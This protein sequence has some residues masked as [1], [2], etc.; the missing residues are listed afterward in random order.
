LV[1]VVNREL[2]ELI[3]EYQRI[4]AIQILSDRR[5]DDF[6][7]FLIKENYIAIFPF[8]NI[9]NNL[10]KFAGL[11]FLDSG[12]LLG[13]NKLKFDTLH[14]IW[15]RFNSLTENQKIK[16]GVNIST[17][18]LPYVSF[19][20]SNDNYSTKLQSIT[21]FLNY[22]RTNS[23]SFFLN[24]L[25]EIEIL[26]KHKGSLI[27]EKNEIRNFGAKSIL[28]YESLRNDFSKDNQLNLSELIENDEINY[29]LFENN[30]LKDISLE[31]INKPISFSKLRKKI[32]DLSGK[33]VDLWKIDLNTNFINSRIDAERFVFLRF[34]LDTS[35]LSYSLYLVFFQLNIGKLTKERRRQMFA[36][37]YPRKHF[38]QK[39]LIIELN[40]P[41][42]AKSIDTLGDYRL[43]INRNIL[44]FY[45][46]ALKLPGHVF[47][48]IT[49]INFIE[50]F[51]SL[52]SLEYVETIK[53]F[54]IVTKKQKDTF[55][56]QKLILNFVRA[57]E[58]FQ[59]TSRHISEEL[60]NYGFAYP[61]SSIPGMIRK[62][63]LD[64]IQRWDWTWVVNGGTFDTDPKYAV[65][66][67]DFLYNKIVINGCSFEQAI[68]DLR[69]FYPNYRVKN[70]LSLFGQLKDKALYDLITK[71][72][73]L[74][75]WLSS[76]DPGLIKS[77]YTQLFYIL[78][79]YNHNRNFSECKS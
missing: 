19:D 40:D 29:Q 23:P 37:Y 13:Y 74:G 28:I 52:V 77:F 72:M 46:K 31:L 18:E 5:L 36:E 22:L 75:H 60:N 56:I 43:V 59:I 45:P 9:K 33:L 51:T 16:I 10:L 79:L 44:G 58:N 15:L 4:H 6:H 24:K 61:S 30:S 69:N 73:L 38:N 67:S 35:F 71:K 49:P 17:N 50:S 27:I 20:Q 39:I 76:E 55:Q 21:N 70:A 14:K 32:L 1:K 11:N 47:P 41:F 48:S 65:S 8:E 78:F 64:L 68:T 54:R 42:K 62:N 66:F 25:S 57:N 26:L 12:F 3:M 34:W 63:K 2:A 53:G 7:K